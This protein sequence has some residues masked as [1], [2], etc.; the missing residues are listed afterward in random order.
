MFSQANNVC[1]ATEIKPD[2]TSVHTQE[3]SWRRDAA[4]VDLESGASYFG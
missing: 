3:R 2:R 4:F 1:V